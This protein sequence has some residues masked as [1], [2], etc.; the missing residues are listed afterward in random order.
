[1][2]FFVVI[3]RSPN[4]NAETNNY[5]KT[6][7]THLVL[8]LILT[9]SV[10]AFGVQTETTAPYLD[11]QLASAR[12]SISGSGLAEVIITCVGKANITRISTV[13]YLERKV[14]SNWVR[15]DIDA[16][17]DQWTYN[18][19]STRMVQN[20][21]QQ[22]SLTGEYRVVAECTIVSPNGTEVLDLDNSDTW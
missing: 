20:Y 18:T 19:T 5:E 22:L 16:A 2:L 13:T 3:S 7:H 8:V 17:N 6:Y 4:N 10:P 1:M 12:I 11:T 21:S 9:M 14:G 15:V